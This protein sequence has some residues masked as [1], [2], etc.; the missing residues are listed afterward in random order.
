[1]FDPAPLRSSLGHTTGISKPQ[2]QNEIFG[3]HVSNVKKR[4]PARLDMLNVLG[5]VWCSTVRVGYVHEPGRTGS[6]AKSCSKKHRNVSQPFQNRWV[7]TSDLPKN[8]FM[9]LC[10]PM[11]A[12]EFRSLKSKIRKGGWHAFHLPPLFSKTGNNKID[13]DHF[14]W[15]GMTAAR[16]NLKRPASQFF[17][18]A[19]PDSP[20]LVLVV[21]PSKRQKQ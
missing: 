3:A 1:M 16:A 14:T 4:A 10:D 13:L 5:D 20:V 12:Y 2:L 21:A 19:N 8:C 15:R 11:K 7:V 9:C 18:A 6:S 17:S